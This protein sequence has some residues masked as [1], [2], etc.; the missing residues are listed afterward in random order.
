QELICLTRDAQR[1][2]REVTCCHGSNIGMNFGKCSGAGLPGHLHM[3][4]VPRWEGDI[5]FM[6]VLSDTRVIPQSIDALRERMA[7]AAV[8]LGLPPIRK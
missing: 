1:L 2:I 7:E 4:I 6:T 8:K 5:N 3:H